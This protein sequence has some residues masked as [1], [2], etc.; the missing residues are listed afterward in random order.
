MRKIST[1]I[2]TYLSDTTK[3]IHGTLSVMCSLNHLAII[4]AAG[5]PEPPPRHDNP[6]EDSDD[7]EGSASE[8]SSSNDR[9]ITM[10]W[11]LSVPRNASAPTIFQLFMRFIHALKAGVGMA[12]TEGNPIVA[13]SL[14]IWSLSGSTNGNSDDHQYDT[15]SVIIA[16]DNCSSRCITNC[17]HD[18]IDQPV[19]VKV[20]VQ[21]IGGS[22]TATYK[23]TVRWAIEDEQ[24]VVHH[25]L[26]P[27][28]YYNAATPF[29]LLSPQHWARA[30]NDNAPRRRGT[31]CAT[32][33]DAVELFWKQRKF[34]RVIKLSASSNIAM[35][36]SAPSYSKLHTFC[37]KARE[38]LGRGPHNEFD[39]MAMPAAVDVTDDE[40][41]SSLDESDGQGSE[42]DRMHPDLPPEATQEQERNDGFQDKMTHAFRMKKDLHRIEQEPVRDERYLKYKTDQA[43]ML[44]WHYRLGHISFERI[45][46]LAEKGDL[47]SKL[48]TARAP[49]CASCMFGKATRRPW[50]TRT[51]NNKAEPLSAD[52]SGAIVGVDQ[53]ISSSPG[54]IGQM[55]GILTRKRYS[56]STVFVDHYSGFTY[57]H[58]QVS[59][60]AEQTI[61][62]KRAFERYAKS[63]GVIVKHYHAD[64]GIFDSKAFTEEVHRCGQS[65]T[66]AGVN[67]HHMNGKAEK[68][69]RDLQEAAR[70]M[71]LHAKQRWPSA[72]NA[73]LW[74]FA[75]REVDTQVG[76]QGQDWCLSWFVSTALEEDSI[77][78]EPKN[79]PSLATVSLSVRRPVRYTEAIVGK[80]HSCFK[81]AREG[82]IHRQGRN[83]PPSWRS[84]EREECNQ[85][86]KSG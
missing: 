33:E 27:D 25:F 49:K 61:M 12:I 75:I 84:F 30:A 35:V 83:R 6:F 50:R 40:S 65:I 15:D 81:V 11:D 29:R 3:A 56:V 62:A 20:S 1:T 54:L 41:D 43:D 59:T 67:A 57:V 23:G 47:P 38:D 14:I 78:P 36:R 10:L 52:F 82:W 16:I 53:M 39:L 5:V 24:G 48:A 18:F 46:K 34:K 58:F 60:S 17:M 45:R 86:R 22:V 74:P 77:G 66:Y 71:I 85:R 37:S 26:I 19:P 72:I 13:C 70:T 55:R 64:N 31:W 42:G 76:A 4:R 8:Y 63:Y 9:T 73:N 7:D 21:G 68:K 51:P 69:I 28:T 44:A 2:V 80:R 79:R 32:Y